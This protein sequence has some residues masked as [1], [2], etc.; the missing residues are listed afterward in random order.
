M[1]T[2]GIL[3]PNLARVLAELGH[4]DT[5]VLCD[6]GLPV[7]SGTERID[8][9][10]KPGEPAYL[11]VL[12]EILEHIVVEAAVLASEIKSVSPQFHQKI[13][14]LLPEG[15]PVEYVDHVDFK[16]RTSEA[17]AIVR[18]GEFTPYVSVILVSGCAY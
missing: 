8:L 17:R 10:W 6:A 12:P 9:A 16:R 1:L 2:K 18:T 15:T 5:L 4:K 3:N 11:D 7:P 13:L 14:D